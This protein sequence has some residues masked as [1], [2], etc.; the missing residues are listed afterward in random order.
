MIVSCEACKTKFRLDPSRLKGDKSKVRC[1][2]CGYVFTVQRPQEEVLLKVD[3]SE[4][5]L[6]F[7]EELTKPPSILGPPGAYASKKK[8]KNKLLVGLI[9][10]LI[11][12]GAGIFLLTKYDSFLT[13]SKSGD[14]KG[15]APTAEEQP[16]VTIL[17]TTQAYFL[18]NANAGQIFVIEGEIANESTKPVSFILLE[19]KI[20]GTDNR[21]AQSQRCFSGN[22]LVREELTRL[23]ITEIQNRMMNREGKNLSNVHILPGNRIAFMLVFH[24][25]PE[26]DALSDYS[27]EVISAKLD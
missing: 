15:N 26:L 24:N 5:D 14:N 18:E 11:I 20:Y 16:S 1:S 4:Q 27:I 7:E 21:V 9:A 6:T 8:T 19:G 2:R 25:L 13:L 10:L 3:L 23:S 17:D 12:L 22:V